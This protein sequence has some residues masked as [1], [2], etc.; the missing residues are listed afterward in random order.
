MVDRRLIITADD[1]GLSTAIDRGIGDA[2]GRG[3][4]R[5]VGALANG[6]T[7]KRA[8]EAVPCNLAVGIHLNLTEGCPVSPHREIANLVDSRGQFYRLTELLV[9]A[10]LGRIPP[11]QVVRET[12]TQIARLRDLGFRLAYADSHQHVHVHPRL[13]RPFVQALQQAHLAHTRW[14]FDRSWG[15]GVVKASCLALATA[16][17][18]TSF[19][20]LSRPRATRG[21]A[22]RP[23]SL[24]QLDV[25]LA[26]LPPGL[27]ELIVHLRAPG[28]IEPSERALADLSLRVAEWRTLTDP[29]V[30]ALLDRHQIQLVAPAAD[31]PPA[32]ERPC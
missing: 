24:A 18:G 17:S 3:V 19:R 10:S 5:A 6:P 23:L 22:R 26:N 11:E 15:P 9:R 25:L 30:L 32:E 14:P 2:V 16:M 4:V 20:G 13:A 7:L 27:S 1:L 28:P 12:A 8:A 31:R 29:R 21:I